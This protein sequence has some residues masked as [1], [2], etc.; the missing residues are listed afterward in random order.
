MKKPNLYIETERLILRPFQDKDYVNWYEGFD[1]RLSSQYKYDDGHADMSNS[2]K[3]WFVQWIEGFHKAAEKDEMYI[4]GVFSKEDGVNV[5]KVELITIL[6]MDYQWAMMGYSIH[7]QFWKNGYGVESVNAAAKV[8]FTELNFHRIELHIN[9]DNEPSKKLAE[10]A[11]FT[12]E[13]KREQFSL[14]NDK[15]TDF[16]IYYQNK[17]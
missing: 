8:F 10:R 9:I 15:W 4:L 12:F 6:R 5:G 7:N 1:N 17:K 2:T 16:L 3:E 14:E 13:C 11:G